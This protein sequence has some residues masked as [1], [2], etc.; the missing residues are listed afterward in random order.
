MV[1]FWGRTVHGLNIFC[2]LWT[3]LGRGE[4]FNELEETSYGKP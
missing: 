2:S 3:I 1:F 4:K